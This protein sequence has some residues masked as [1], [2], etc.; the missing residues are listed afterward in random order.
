MADPI[1]HANAATAAIAATTGGL[2]VGIDPFPLVT[3]VF[4]A[5]TVLSFV[6]DLPLKKII[7]P[8]IAIPLLTS[9][10]TPLLLKMVTHYFSWLDG[11]QF[12]NAAVSGICAAFLSS[13]FFKE[14]RD[15]IVSKLTFKLWGAQ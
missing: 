6:E 2:L 11:T 15:F 9:A 14:V 13:L 3:S 5:W 10:L 7:M 12:L 4:A 8:G 1:T